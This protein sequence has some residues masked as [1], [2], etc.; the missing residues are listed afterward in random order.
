MYI[1][2]VETTGPYCSAAIIDEKG[3]VKSRESHERLNH[4]KTLMPMIKELINEV[5]IKQS[6]ITAVAAS[7]GPGSFTGIR[8]GVSSAKSMAQ[9]LGIKCIGVPTLYAFAYGQQEEAE[10]AGAGLICPVFDARRKQIYACCCMGDETIIKGSAYEP[11]EFFERA[12]KEA[13]KREVAK[14][15]F[16]GD[17]IAV[18]EDMIKNC[19][20][21]SKIDVCIKKE[22]YQNAEAVAK[23]AMDMYK[24]GEAVFFEELKPEYM[25]K[26][27]AQRNLEERLNRQL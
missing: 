13:K 23:I 25:R 17:G 24:K 14:V 21:A 1:L 4:L 27:E 26:P 3:H 10:K 8:I 5:G 22:T 20:K 19:M 2:A 16:A 9:V 6:D 7:K 12:A 18:Y 15:L 11:E